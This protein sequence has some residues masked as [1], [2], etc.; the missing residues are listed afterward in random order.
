MV[1][2]GGAAI[3]HESVIFAIDCGSGRVCFLAE[4][5]LEGRR[6]APVG[7]LVSLHSS[8]STLNCICFLGIVRLGSGSL[9]ILSGVYK[10]PGTSAKKRLGSAASTSRVLRVIKLFYFFSIHLHDMVTTTLD[11][12]SIAF[13]SSHR[14]VIVVFKCRIGICVRASLSL[15]MFVGAGLS[16]GTH[17][18]FGV[19]GLGSRNFVRGRLQ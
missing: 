19:G 8:K 6:R 16:N 14:I 2:S 1:I 7:S 18:I 12:L 3:V 9:L 10:M 13:F 4:F 17:Q 15:R 11:L 5:G